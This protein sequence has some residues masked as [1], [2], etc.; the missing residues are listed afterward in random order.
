M[1][2]RDGEVMER[3]LLL[4]TVGVRHLMLES[5]EFL[6]TPYIQAKETPTWELWGSF[7]GGLSEELSEVTVISPVMWG[8]S[9]SYL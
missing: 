7:G 6:E 2:L 1:P 4:L 3:V 5:Q 8:A 9:I